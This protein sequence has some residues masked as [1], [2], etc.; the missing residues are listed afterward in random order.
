MLSI[1]GCKCEE[2]FRSFSGGSKTP[3][4]ST[5]ARPAVSSPTEAT[6]DA[7]TTGSISIFGG[8]GCTRVFSAHSRGGRRSSHVF[9]LQGVSADSAWQFDRF[10]RS[11]R[12][13]A[14]HL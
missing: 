11:C 13:H 12:V 5:K 4:P 2:A 8:R 10:P 6:H 9:A 1:F 3:W 7:Q 14:R